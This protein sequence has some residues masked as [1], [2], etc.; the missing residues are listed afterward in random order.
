MRC[1]GKEEFLGECPSLG[2]DGGGC[3]RRRDAGVKCDVTPLRPEP[4]V[5]RREPSCGLRKMEEEE[6]SSR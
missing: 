6:R 3:R 5:G 1:T 4:P 2:Q